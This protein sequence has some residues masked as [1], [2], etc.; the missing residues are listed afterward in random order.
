MWKSIIG[1]VSFLLLSSC[2]LL[3]LS[4]PQNDTPHHVALMHQDQVLGIH[5]KLSPNKTDLTSPAANRS[6]ANNIVPS[7]VHVIWFYPHNTTFRFHH[8][9]CLL[10][11]HR[12]LQPKVILFWYNNH[13]TGPWWTFAKETVPSIDMM[14]KAPPTSI[15]SQPVIVP[16]HQSDIARIEILLKFGGIYLD[17]DVIA[18]KPFRSLLR[19][20]VTMGAETPELLGSG[21]ILA[22][23]DAAF[24]KLWQNAYHNFDDKQWNEH[25]V[26]MPMQ[27]AQQHPN[28]VHIDW[29][30]LQRPNWDEREW[31]YEEGKLWD[32]QAN[33]AVHLWYR[34]YNVDHNPNSIQNWN[35]TAGE[36]FRYIYY[37]TPDLIP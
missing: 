4:F 32:W 19:H 36:V 5:V 26:H 25:S 13:P 22:K 33:L 23:K 20:P 30:S 6:T 31:L 3:H 37:G 11:I 24:L 7:L 1:K 35:T 34:E 15:F 12:H 2:L 17:L 8:M 18:V 29:F 10:S 21:I 28:L 14:Y 9:L 16:E 27:I